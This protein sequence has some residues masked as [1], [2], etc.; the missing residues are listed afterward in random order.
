MLQ[1]SIVYNIQ[2]EPCAEEPAH[3]N[4]QL[5]VRNYLTPANS[6]SLA[7][8]TQVSEGSIQRYNRSLSSCVWPVWST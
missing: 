5:F 8:Y 4:T 2:A 3:A 1:V 7:N 6:V